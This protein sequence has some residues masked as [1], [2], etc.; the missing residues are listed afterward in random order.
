MKKKLTRRLSDSD[1]I[2]S[3]SEIIPISNTIEKIRIIRTSFNVL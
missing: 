2:R 3:Y 1:M